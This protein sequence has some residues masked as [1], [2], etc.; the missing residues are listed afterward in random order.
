M[1]KNPVL[2]SILYISLPETMQR[3][4]GSFKIDPSILL[5]V[6]TLSQSP[7]FQPE[8]LT[9]EM[10]L[11]GM[12]KVIGY[13]PENEY[14]SYYKDFVLALHP[15]IV[16]ELNKT[17]IIKAEQNDFPLAEEIFL[18]LSGLAPDDSNIALNLAFVYEKHA[19]SLERLGKLREAEKYQERLFLQYKTALNKYSGN[20]AVLYQAGHYFLRQNSFTKALNCFN[21]YLKSPESKARKSEAEKITAL[22]SNQSEL[23]TLFSEAFDFIKLGKEKEGIPKIK[24]FLEKQPG[25]WNG[26]FLL[27]WAQRRL[28]EYREA[29]EAFLKALS[30]FPDHVDTLN[31]LSICFMELEEYGQSEK[32]LKRAL[33]LEPENIK[34]ISN[35]GILALKQNNIPDAEGFFK[36]VLLYS[37]EDP[38]ARHYLNFIQSYK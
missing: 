26:W 25:L 7:S 34:I 1:E 29:S 14:F 11:S 16:E 24:L 2:D 9:W 21:S 8:E 20:S 18:I 36:T 33:T 32:Y 19:E 35:L 27:G 12:L 37:A 4:I 28:S 38:I 22:L 3:S 15:G 5:P 30:L 10:I 31:E 23:D 6:D 13:D 17:G